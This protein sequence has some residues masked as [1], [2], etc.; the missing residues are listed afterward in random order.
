MVLCLNVVST[1]WQM[2]VKEENRPKT[3]FSTHHGQFLLKSHEWAGKLYQTDATRG[4]FNKTSTL[5]I[6]KCSYCFQRLKQW[7]HL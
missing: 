1:N 7:L 6:Y 5:V 3:A 2:Q 4:Q